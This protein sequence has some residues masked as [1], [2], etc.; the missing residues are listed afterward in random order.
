MST[1]EHAPVKNPVLAGF[2]RQADALVAQMSVEEQALLLS[3]DG[4]WQTHGIE[5]LGLAPMVVSDGPHGLRKVNGPGLDGSVPATCFPTAPGLAATWNTALAREVGAALGLEA[6]ASGVHIVLGPGINMKRS[7]LGGRNFEYFSEDPVL[8]G[9]MAAA[10]IDGVQGQGVGTSLKHFAVNNQEFERMSTSSDVDERTLHEIYLQA[11]EIA[12]AQVPPEA[13]PWSVMSSYN[14]INGVQASEHRELLTGILRERWGYEGFVVSDW[15]GIR[16]RVAGVIAGNHLEMPGSGAHNRQKIIDAVHAGALDRAVLARVTAELVAV[17][18]MAHARHRPGSTFDAEA[19]HAL[20][21]RVGAEGIVLL[22]NEGNVLPLAAGTRVA[23]I[24][25]FAQAPRYQGAGSSQVNPTRVARPHDELVALLGAEQVRHARGCDEEGVTTDALVAEAVAVAQAC[26][27]VLVFAGLPDSYESEGFDRR[28]IDLPPGQDRLIE[29]LAAAHPKVVV[30]LM[31]GSA[32]AMPWVDSV[33]AIVEGWLGGQ[34]GGG[35]IADVLTGRVNPSGKLSETFPVSLQQTAA[36]PNFPGRDG[37]AWYGEGLFIGYRHHDKRGLQPLFPFGHGL[38][39]TRYDYTAIRTDASTFDVD[40][41]LDGG[42]RLVVEATLENTGERAG[43]E[44]VQLYVRERAPHVVR[45][46]RELRAFAKVSLAPGAST[47]VRFE[48]G[49]RDF[50]HYDIGLHDWAVTP[51][52]YDIQVGGSSRELPLCATVEVQAS[53]ARRQPL[54]RQS[55][56]QDFLGRPGGQAAYD[57]LLRALGMGGLVD[58]VDEA[59][60]AKL[61]PEQLAAKRKGDRGALAFAN[62]MP[63]YKLPA[64]S[65]GRCSDARIDALVR[66]FGG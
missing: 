11:F 47:T 60:L 56:V 21:R 48:L 14:L 36:W 19:H 37:Q 13:Q 63:L 40:A 53:R 15:G 3:G 62:E 52:T 5:R 26:D 9:R 61:T 1:A 23:V 7:P 58:P 49:R 57:E 24:G 41:D 20:S 30:V 55:M 65:G 12:I 38:S 18:L 43:Q 66:V 16:D 31:N 25:D 2:R 51:G 64:M 6:Q 54:T 32:V 35:A 42:G 10:Y 4:W 34:A 50:A 33:P 59:A 39:Y 22:K 27:V 44:V 45:P 8:A 29:A 17:I 28:H 46:E